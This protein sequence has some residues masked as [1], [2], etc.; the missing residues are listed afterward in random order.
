MPVAR[1]ARRGY[2]LL[3][4]RH[5]LRAALLSV[6][7]ER[8]TIRV[9]TERPYDQRHPSQPH[10]PEMHAKHTAEFVRLLS[11]LSYLKTFVAMVGLVWCPVAERVVSMTMARLG[12]KGQIVIPKP[13][14][15]ALGLRPG[16]RI[17]F[18]VDNQG[19]VLI[20]LPV[21]HIEELRGALRSDRPVQL[22]DARRAYGEH[23]A[24]KFGFDNPQEP[25]PSAGSNVPRNRE[26]GLL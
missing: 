16:D 17:V 10:R 15:Q 3:S 1:G 23:L 12:P 13:V 19:A 26:G 2:S 22:E 9:E 24:R 11:L 18:H 6:G 20:P 25:P 4:G 21:S 5:L 14:R 8:P 7:D